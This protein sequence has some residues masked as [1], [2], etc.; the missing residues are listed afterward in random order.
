[1]TPKELLI[2][3][4]GLI[5]KFSLKV[6]IELEE[7]DPHSFLFTWH[8]SEV[9]EETLFLLLIEADSFVQEQ[10]EGFSET[11]NSDLGQGVYRVMAYAPT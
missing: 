4:E 5:K 11:G 1:M 8:P 10:W 6:G 7:G 9:E 3:L 2:K